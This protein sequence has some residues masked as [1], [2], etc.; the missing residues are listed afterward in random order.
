VGLEIITIEAVLEVVGF[1]GGAISNAK[2]E[3]SK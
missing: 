2:I 3:I 1:I